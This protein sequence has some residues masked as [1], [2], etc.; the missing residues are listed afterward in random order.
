MAH[1][2]P[3][4]L[5]LI[6]TLCYAQVDATFT[7]SKPVTA[8]IRVPL[9]DASKTTT[10]STNVLWVEAK[11]LQEGATLLC[12]NPDIVIVSYEAVMSVKGEIFKWAAKSNKVGDQ[13]IMMAKRLQDKKDKLIITITEVYL[14]GKVSKANWMYRL[15]IKQ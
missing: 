9:Y 14:N 8:V 10:D 2:L 13:L 11:D 7:I 15:R 12:W 1:L 6:S 4:L 5:L 3:Y